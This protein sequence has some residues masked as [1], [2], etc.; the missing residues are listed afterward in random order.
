MRVGAQRREVANSIA[1]SRSNE[2]PPQRACPGGV[3]APRRSSAGI[4]SRW[5]YFRTAA[6][7]RVQSGR[8]GYP[9]HPDEREIVG[10][11][12]GAHAEFSITAVSSLIVL[13]LRMTRTTR[14]LHAL[15][16][17][18]VGVQISTRSTSRLRSA[19]APPAARASSA[20]NSIMGHTVTPSAVSASS[21]SGTGPEV[22][23][24]RRPSYPAHI[25]FRNDR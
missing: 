9:R 22:V 19:I 25:R 15:R 17:V 24:C 4:A 12:F 23:R 2:R 1:R 16:Q 14:V 7:D 21:S 3:H 18:L 11:R 5:R 13:V 10:N 20:S 6:E 8:P